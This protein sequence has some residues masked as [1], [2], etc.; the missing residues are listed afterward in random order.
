[1][2]SRLAHGMQDAT[3][4]RVGRI[5]SARITLLLFDISGLTSELLE[6]SCIAHVLADQ[7]Q[8][9]SSRELTLTSEVSFA[10][11]S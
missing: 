1:M 5:V 11:S 8:Q 9:I 3:G 10:S 7:M 6:C 2:S 4:P